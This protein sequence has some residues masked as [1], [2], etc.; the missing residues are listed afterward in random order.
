MKNSVTIEGSSL[1]CSFVV[2]LAFVTNKNGASKLNSVT[3]L[4]PNMVFK[5]NN[6]NQFSPPL[7]E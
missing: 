4:A 3:I 5:T 2:I 7:I 1:L 6:T